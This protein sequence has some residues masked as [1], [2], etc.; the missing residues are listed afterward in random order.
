MHVM[1]VTGNHAVVV[2]NYSCFVFTMLIHGQEM[3]EGPK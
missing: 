3:C 2:I 1:A